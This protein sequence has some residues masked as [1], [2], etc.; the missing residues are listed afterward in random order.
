M[1]HSDQFTSPRP[2]LVT[3]EKEW[4]SEKRPLKY[5]K[6]LENKNTTIPYPKIRAF[7]DLLLTSKFQGPRAERGGW[8]SAGCA[9]DTNGNKGQAKFY[10][11]ATLGN[12]SKLRGTAVRA[13]P[14]RPS[15]QCFDSVGPWSVRIWR[16]QQLLAVKTVWY[17]PDG[18]LLD[19]QHKGKQSAHSTKSSP[20]PREF[21]EDNNSHPELM[22]TR[23]S[24]VVTV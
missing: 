7:K 8:I 23:N 12:G 18:N 3:F 1:W 5:R 19:G 15:Q 13:L 2:D 10:V 9:H 11:P 22:Q 24:H 17:K 4:K 14:A 6:P 21:R 16:R 20:C